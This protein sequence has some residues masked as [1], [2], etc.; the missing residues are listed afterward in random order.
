MTHFF[1]FSLLLG[2]FILWTQRSASQETVAVMSLGRDCT[3]VVTSLGRDCT[4]AVTSLESWLCRERGITG[5][6][7]T[8]A[9]IGLFT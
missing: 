7:V 4:V 9:L 6:D 2:D 8:R 5:V 1:L 3:V